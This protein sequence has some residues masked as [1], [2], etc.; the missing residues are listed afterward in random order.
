MKK[1]LIMVNLVAGTGKAASLLPEVLN[2]L[3]SRDCEVT[4]YPIK[5]EAHLNAEEILRKTEGRFDTVLCI[6]GDGTLNHM[7]NGMM[8]LSHRVPYAFI[9]LGS[10]NDFSKSLNDGKD[11]T[12]ADVIDAITEGQP[13]AYDIGRFNAK[14]FNYVAAFGAFTDVSYTT[15]QDLKNVFGYGAYVMN[16]LGTLP[17]GL[18]TRLHTTV[19]CDEETFEGDYAFGGICNSRSVGGV[20]SPWLADA[21]LTDGKFELIL[22]DALKDIFELNEIVA[23]LRRGDTSNPH[24]HLYQGSDFRFTFD[25]PVGWTLDGEDGGKVTEAEIQ[26]QAGAISIML[27]NKSS[28]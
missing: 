25:Q 10:C 13:Y 23:G 1:V 12:V 14:Y 19:T 18:S 5:P 15:R 24:L 28:V 22:I 2:G 6:G 26:V 21:L 20:Q 16:A 7:I 11:P 4:V 17:N 27:K 8:A 3:A 9:P